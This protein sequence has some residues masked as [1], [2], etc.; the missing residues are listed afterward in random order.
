MNGFVLLNCA[1][2]S[3]KATAADYLRPYRNSQY[4]RGA[5]APLVGL[6]AEPGSLS[7]EIEFDHDEQ[8]VLTYVVNAS[9]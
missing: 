1:T 7:V 8:A 3:S 9:P 5:M 4:E 6:G 2:M